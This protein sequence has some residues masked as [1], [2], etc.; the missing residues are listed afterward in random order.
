[1][2][3][4]RIIFAIFHKQIKDVL[5]NTSVLILFF[6]YPII[7]FVMTTAMSEQLGQASFFISI[8]GTMHA[9]F[10]PIVTSAAI[11]AEEKEKNTLR[12]LIMSNV[13]PF[14]YLISIGG[15]VFI[16]TLLTGSSFI[17][18]GNYGGI[19]ALNFIL[20]MAIGCIC[21]IILG[22]SIGGSAK[23]MMGANAI[24][25]PFGM[26]F[27]FLPMLSSFNKSIEKLS[28][29]TYGQQVSNLIST[30]ENIGFSLDNIAV[31]SVNLLLF[32]FAFVIVFRRNRLED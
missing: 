10:T 24:A 11:I 28:K 30:P 6:I 5:K 8:F 1:M 7:A 20:Y 32:L 9:V 18:I 29:F 16:C 31:I 21:S 4:S 25:V 27:A 23:N 12:V 2:E 22:L 14:E 13:K 19:T 3:C 26:L 17:A 15:F